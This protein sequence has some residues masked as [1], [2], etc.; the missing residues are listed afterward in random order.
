MS[1]LGSRIV[2]LSPVDQP[3]EK[4]VSIGCNEL[5]M[6]VH[7]QNQ[8]RQVC[9]T[10]C[11]SNWAWGVG[12]WV[13]SGHRLLFVHPLGEGARHST[14]TPAKQKPS[15]S[16]QMG[17]CLHPPPSPPPGWAS[18]IAGWAGR[19]ACWLGADWIL[20]WCWDQDPGL[21]S[22]MR[23]VVGAFSSWFSVA[24]ADKT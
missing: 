13:A 21:D 11:V 1:A 17:V 16:G 19:A 10:L 6:P 24:P 9:Q 4:D 7:Q 20:T 23:G 3:V 22:R 5:N 15:P 8:A 14:L 12:T 18:F 2:L